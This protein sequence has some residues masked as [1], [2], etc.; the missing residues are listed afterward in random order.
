[1]RRVLID[2]NLYIDWM[3]TGAHEATMTGPDL[4]R[5]LSAVVLMELEAGAKTLAARRAVKQLADTFVRV[6][7]FAAPSTTAF[8]RAGPLLRS[9][10]MRGREI[11]RASFV[12]DLLIALTAREL[13]ATVLTN[14]ASDF[15][16]I[17]RVLDFSLTVV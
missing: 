3:N 16:E 12:N 9:L 15:A 17:E 4:V 1:M 2:T 14:D 5:H 8:L 7:R 6:D 13:G 11:R 10:R